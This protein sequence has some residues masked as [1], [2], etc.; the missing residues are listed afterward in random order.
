ERVHLHQPANDQPIDRHP[1]RPPPVRVATEHACIGLGRQIIDPIFTSLEVEHKG[2]VTVILRQRPYAVRTEEL[3][4]VEHIAQN[5]TELLLVDHRRQPASLISSGRWVIGPDQLLIYLWMAL[6]EQ[7]NLFKD[8]GVLLESACL[9]YGGGT[10]RQQ[11][12]HRA[13]LQ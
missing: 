7:L 1:D 8:L 3:V 5:A 6:P 11:S 9:E 2:M 4:L 12:H 13:D 10:E